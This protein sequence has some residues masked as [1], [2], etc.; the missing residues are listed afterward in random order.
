MVKASGSIIRNLLEDQI[1]LCKH[2]DVAVFL[3]GGVDS[4][5]IAFAADSL[6]K[7]ITG[8]SFCLEGNE[9]YD[10]LKAKEACD[11]F[12][13]NFNG[14]KVPISSD[15]VVEKWKELSYRWSCKKKTEFECTYPFLFIY[16]IVLE[17]EVFSGLGADSSYGLSKKAALHWLDTKEKFDQYRLKAYTDGPGGWRQQEMLSFAYNVHY[18][19]PYMDWSIRN[20]LLTLSWK[21]I[22]TPCQKG[23][24]VEGFKEYFTKLKKWKKHSNLQLESGINKLF[25]DVILNNKEINFRGRKRIMDIARDWN[26]PRVC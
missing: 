17:Y 10:Y 26:I 6:G 7:K 4:L 8:Y 23:I 12:G 9:S 15:I 24:V 2:N 20:Y 22:H 21:E 14:V 3:S 19:A 1:S 5:S 18:N 25:E 16:P 13:W 11:I